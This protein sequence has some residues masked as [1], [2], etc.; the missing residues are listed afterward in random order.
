[1]RWE[2]IMYIDS[3]TICRYAM[4]GY[5]RLL[6]T[7]ASVKMWGQICADR[8]IGTDINGCLAVPANY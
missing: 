8:Q 1:M 4:P 3:Y 5:S 6:Q 2:Y 7:V